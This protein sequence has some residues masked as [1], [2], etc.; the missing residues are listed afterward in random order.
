MNEGELTPLP[1]SSVYGQNYCYG[2]KYAAKCQ[3]TG[4]LRPISFVFIG[5]RICPIVPN[6]EYSQLEF[7]AA[8]RAA[9]RCFEAVLRFL[10]ISVKVFA[11]HLSVGRKKSI[12]AKMPVQFFGRR[13]EV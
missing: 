6:G 1:P 12:E 2:S 13:W 8:E 11:C 7:E 3:Y 10:D 4:N 9:E 5:I